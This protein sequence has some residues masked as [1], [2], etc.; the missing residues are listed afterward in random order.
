[1]DI[2]MQHCG[3]YVFAHLIR[4]F[5]SIEL[6]IAMLAASPGKLNGLIRTIIVETIRNNDVSSILFLGCFDLNN[7]YIMYVILSGFFLS[8]SS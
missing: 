6:F 2:S 5:W 4:N 3:V 8:S 7:Y 1:V